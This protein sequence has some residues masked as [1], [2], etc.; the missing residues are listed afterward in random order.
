MATIS[1]P[2]SL[3][4]AALS[5]SSSSNNMASAIPNSY[6][7]TKA[8]DNPIQ[9]MAPGL[10]LIGAFNIPSIVFAIIAHRIAK[11]NNAS[12]GW[13]VAATLTGVLLPPTAL[14][15]YFRIHPLGNI[16]G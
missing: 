1:T 16:I 15:L 12:M 7:Q 11:H 6:Q 14:F 9:D 10:L 3:L 13:V 4:S 5:T 2:T 8:Q